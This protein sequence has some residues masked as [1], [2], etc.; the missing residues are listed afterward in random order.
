MSYGY[1][2]T[3]SEDGLLGVYSTMRKAEAAVAEYMADMEYHIEID[4][5][6]KEKCQQWIWFKGGTYARIDRWLIQ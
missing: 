1:T 3:F 4:S 5:I 2:V 6:T